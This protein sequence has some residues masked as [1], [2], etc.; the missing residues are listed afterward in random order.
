MEKKNSPNKNII[1]SYMSNNSN[2]QFHQWQNKFN[3][4]KLKV[5]QAYTQ[6]P[7]LHVINSS[8]S[9]ITKS[10]LFKEKNKPEMPQYQ[11]TFDDIE[12]NR[13][14][15][16]QTNSNHKEMNNSSKKLSPFKTLEMNTNGLFITKDLTPGKVCVSQKELTP[17]P[18]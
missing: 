6:N 10:M 17:G 8:L 7:N 15:A 14:G 1:N 12:A 13:T 16:E 3:D 18:Y 4:I 5:S 2:T 9:D 11:V